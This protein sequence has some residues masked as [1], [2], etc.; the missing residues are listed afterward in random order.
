MPIPDFDQYGLLP[1]GIH[2]CSIK[3]VE[4]RFGWNT[5]RK[6]L[7]GLLGNFL[8]QEVRTKF[9]QPFYVNGSF[10][11]DKEEPNDVDVVLDMRLA[12][13]GEKWRALVLMQSRQEQFRQ[14][15]CVDFWI[16]LPAQ[17]EFSDF[18]QY[19]GTKTARFKGL[20][21]RHRKGILRVV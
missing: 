11:T 15:Y 10:V 20:N 17:N 14:Q 3:E 6:R 16:N 5:H 2:Q 4:A 1:V 7:V 21:P 13:D 9:V 12:T 8:L 19:V 18:F